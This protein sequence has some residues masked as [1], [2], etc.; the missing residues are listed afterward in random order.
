[1]GSMNATRSV[2][3]G[4]VSEPHPTPISSFDCQIGA[5]TPVYLALLPAGTSEPQGEFLTDRKVLKGY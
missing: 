1:M 5:D 4:R 3:E 2:E